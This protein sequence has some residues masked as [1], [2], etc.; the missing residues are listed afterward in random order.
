MIISK[1][2]SMRSF[3]DAGLAKY[4]DLLKNRTKSL[5][6]DLESLIADPSFSEPLSIDLNW[7]TVNNRRDLAE[8]MWE[9]FGQ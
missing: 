8:V 4:E 2:L 6:K 7:K 3:N 9:V 1:Q 5:F